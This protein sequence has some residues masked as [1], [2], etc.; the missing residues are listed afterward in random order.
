MLQLLQ[1]PGNRITH[2][3][4]RGNKRLENFFLEPGAAADAVNALGWPP[5]PVAVPEGDINVTTLLPEP[6]AGIN[7]IY[8]GVT[9]L[10]VAAANNQTDVIKK[11]VNC[12]RTDGCTH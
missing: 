7:T 1:I 5:P 2:R 4:Q 12:D 10:I 6:D 9:P 8:T 11:L 3:P